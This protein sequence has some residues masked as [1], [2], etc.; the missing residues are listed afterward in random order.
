MLA[1]VRNWLGSA[2]A[3][4]QLCARDDGHSADHL[5]AGAGKGVRHRTAIGESGREA[6]VSVDAQVRLNKLDELVEEGDILAILVAPASVQ[7]IRN[8][9]D[10]RVVCNGL[11]SVERE[12]TT[13]VGVLTVDNL[14]GG[15]TKLMPSENEAVG[16][17]LVV[18][19]WDVEEVVA[20]LAIHLHRILLRCEGLS[21]AATSRVGG[22]DG[23]DR[24]Q[25]KAC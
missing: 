3:P 15:S 11:Q 22:E 6:Q 24:R 25:E 10:S 9:K 14:L 21:L 8:H 20:V 17:V 18:V 16:V 12:G 23:R 5:W 2:G 13:A 1:V 19:V 4:A 7:T